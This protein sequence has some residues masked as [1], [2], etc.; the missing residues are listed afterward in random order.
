MK[1]VNK[2]FKVIVDTNIWISFLIGKILRGLQYYINDR[3]VFITS[4]D[5]QV[6]ELKEVFRKPKIKKYFTP[7]Q[8]EEFFELFFEAAEVVPLKSKTDL[9][10]DPK[11][12]YLLSLATDANAD[13]L[14]T[15]DKDL[16]VLEKI[17]QTQIIKYSAFE[18]LLNH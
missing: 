3:T 4:C 11:D 9:C 2:S 1:K 10:R 17:N 16:L 12:N 7:E 6:Q 8:T 14:I 15:G 13:Y 5:E 18:K